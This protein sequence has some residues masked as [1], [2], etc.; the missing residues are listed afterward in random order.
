MLERAVLCATC[1]RDIATSPRS[2]CDW[3]VVWNVEELVSGRAQLGVI[4]REVKRAS[5]Q[6]KGL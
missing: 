1:K 3:H 2:R 4:A 5:K 6:F